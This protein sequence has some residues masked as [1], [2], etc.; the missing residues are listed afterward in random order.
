M[1]WQLL[2]QCGGGITKKIQ[3]LR[4]LHRASENAERLAQTEGYPWN[5]K[6]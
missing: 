4:P 1:H 6:K 3:R 2:R 5:N